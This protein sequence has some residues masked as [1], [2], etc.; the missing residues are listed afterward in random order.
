MTLEKLN[1]RLTKVEAYGIKTLWRIKMTNWTKIVT[2][3]G[4][5]AEE[6]DKWRSLTGILRWNKR[7]V[8]DKIF[9]DVYTDKTQATSN[10]PISN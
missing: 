4:K 10:Q 8:K 1:T 5:E 2:V 3:E 7:K 6:I 9:L